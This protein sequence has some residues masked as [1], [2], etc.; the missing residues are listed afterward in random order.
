MVRMAVVGAQDAAP[1]H[2]D[3]MAGETRVAIPVRAALARTQPAGA[4][5][6]GGV[7]VA[8][9]VVVVAAAPA[10][11]V[12]AGAAEVVAPLPYIAGPIPDWH[13]G[14]SPRPYR[15]RP[16][17]S[18]EGGC[19]PSGTFEACPARSCAAQGVAFPAESSPLPAFVCP[20]RPW[21]AA[22]SASTLPHRPTVAVGRVIRALAGPVWAAGVWEEVLQAEG[23][24]PWLPAAA[25]HGGA[26]T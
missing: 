21:H 13:S 2:M 3:G 26:S 24:G 11:G 5:G 12:A 14:D 23:E 17:G 20:A 4:V 6:R 10:A 25:G 18:C 8:V 16:S 15:R 1:E 22:S 9:M 7:V 19:H